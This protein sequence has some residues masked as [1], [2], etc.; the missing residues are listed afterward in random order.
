MTVFPP[1]APV[2]VSLD[3]RPLPSYVRAYVA[4]GRVFA[5]VRPLLSRLADRLWFEGNVLVIVRDGRTV[6]IPLG[7]RT[8]DALDSAFVTIVPVLQALGE[9]VS[10]D[11]RL[12]LLDVRTTRSYGIA[13][14]PPFVP[15]PSSSPR[16]VFTPEPIATPRPVW[17]G[18]PLPR[19]T[20][21]PEP[22]P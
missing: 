18:S 7:A 21:L 9:S 3:G 14:E 11:A 19:R 13:T 10:Y 5:P 12:R 17:S 22:P 16:V 1:G 8:P 2:T 20:P 4:D 6:R 15:G